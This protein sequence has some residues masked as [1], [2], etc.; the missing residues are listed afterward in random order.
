MSEPQGNI[1]TQIDAE[2]KQ[3]Q[4][5]VPSQSAPT[6]PTAPTPLTPSQGGNIFTQIDAEHKQAA[7]DNDPMSQ[8][9]SIGSEER[10]FLQNNPKYK[11]VPADPTFRNRPAG[12]Y[13]DP[14]L[15]ENKWRNNP[16]TD[17]APID[18][19]LLKHSLQGAGVG[20][21][22]AA[23]ALGLPVAAPLLEEGAG[24][25]AEYAEHFGR[26]GVEAIKA[27]AKAHPEATKAIVKTLMGT[28]GGAGFGHSS[29]GALIG[30]LASLL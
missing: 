9:H 30:L 24:L 23:G 10:Q 4:P 22:P 17:Q 20:A 18:L 1:F 7:T 3:S 12:I 19:H 26:Q 11:Y 13:P 15:P 28:V 21:I 8:D 29:T 5:T 27:M 16:D 25:A 14:S 6:A 2:Q